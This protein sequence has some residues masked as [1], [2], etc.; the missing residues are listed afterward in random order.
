MR[1]VARVVRKAQARWAR[2]ERNVVAENVDGSIVVELP[3]QGV[4]WLVKEIL[5]EAGD[6][7]VLE[8]A[9]ARQ[10]VLHAAE[11]LLASTP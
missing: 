5:K 11:S 7:A 8:P 2:E 9:E 10:A 4:D 1:C 3:F 6:A